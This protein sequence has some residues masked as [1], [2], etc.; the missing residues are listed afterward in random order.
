MNTC[1]ST[2]AEYKRSVTAIDLRERVVH[3]H[4]DRGSL[5]QGVFILQ[6]RH[7]HL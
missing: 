2:R 5:L 4:R 7:E 1:R 3:R 6:G